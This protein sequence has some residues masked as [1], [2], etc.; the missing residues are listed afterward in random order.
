MLLPA[1]SGDGR[2]AAPTK[3][4]KEEIE[5]WELVYDPETGTLIGSTET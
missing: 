3:F 4:N 5:K 2:I 1:K